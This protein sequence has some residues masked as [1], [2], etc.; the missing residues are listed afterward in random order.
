MAQPG[1]AAS[2]NPVRLDDKTVLVTGGASGIGL[3]LATRLLA[4]GNRV[5]VCGRDPGK[6]DAA[7]QAHPGLA[8][9]KCD[10]TEA[11]DIER[12]GAT[13]DHR[14]GGLDLLINNA[15][16]Q[17]NYRF[18]D[19]ADHGER[20]DAEVGIN[21][22]AQVRLTDAMLP[23]LFASPDGAIVNVTS[24]LA[25]VPKESAPVYCATKAGLRVFTQALRYQ[26]EGGPV[27]VFEV[28]PALVDTAMTAGR[29]RNKLSPA[30]L[31][32]EVIDGLRRDRPTIL[33][34]KT[35]LLF[36]LDRC[37]PGLAARIIR[38]G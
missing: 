18:D 7:V 20:I 10:I 17:Y 30:A 9:L 6:L 16:V 13:L 14:Y 3:A 2:E 33:V 34:G 1:A 28:V 25:R 38:K 21:F 35:R 24:A 12:L 15:G 29:G 27:R 37:L 11:A 23:R 31:A 36:A 5:L 8:V 4:L 19:G 32:Q 26:L 22:T